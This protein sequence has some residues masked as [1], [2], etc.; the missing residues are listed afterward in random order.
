M[1]KFQMRAAPP[2]MWVKERSERIW[3]RLSAKNPNFFWFGRFSQNWRNYAKVGFWSSPFWPKSIDFARFSFSEIL[4]LPSLAQFRQFCE[5][6]TKSKEILTL[7]TQAIPNPFRPLLNSHFRRSCAHLKF[8]HFRQ[9]RH[10]NYRK[11]AFPSYSPPKGSNS[12]EKITFPTQNRKKK[13]A[14]YGFLG[15][16]GLSF[17][18]VEISNFFT[19]KKALGIRV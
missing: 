6:P 7:R 10:K 5:K 15:C 16:F 4:V 12:V 3:N 2:E 11:I 8:G 19:P 17:S 1:P 9:N 13:I 18:G 14:L